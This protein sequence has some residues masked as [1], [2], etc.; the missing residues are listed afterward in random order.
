MSLSFFSRLLGL[1]FICSRGGGNRL[2]SSAPAQIISEQAAATNDC[3][4][5][6]TNELVLTRTVDGD[7]DLRS[8]PAGR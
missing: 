6:P 8:H 2:V 5:G 3:G 4:F 1:V 7:G